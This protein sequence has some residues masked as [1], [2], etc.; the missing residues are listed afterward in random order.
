MQY[1]TPV[2]CGPSLNTWPRCAS[3]KAQFTA[4]R[5]I[6][7]LASRS[8][9]IFS[10]AMGPRN[11]A[12]RSRT[13]ISCPNRTGIVATDAPVQPLLMQ[14]PVFPRKRH[15]RIGIPRNVERIG[16]KQLLPLSLRLY[17]L[18]HADFP[19][20]FSVVGELDNG[21]FFRHIFHSGGDNS[22]CAASRPKPSLRRR[23][24]RLLETS[25]AASFA[26]PCRDPTQ[27]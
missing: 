20:F 8:E 21:R 1:R 22:R 25:S 19:Q 26:H 27:T 5:T 13:Q 7:K 3:H 2:G 6:P 9:W 15:L 17:N 23:W 24:L 10:S 18:R 12:T 11:S 16:R 4:V 14:V